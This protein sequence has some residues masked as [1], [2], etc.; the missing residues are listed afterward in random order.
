MFWDQNTMMPPGGAEARA[1]MADTLERTIHAR[2]TDPALGRLL[3][4]LEPWAAGQD[5]ESDDA[6]LDPLGAARLREGGP[7]ARRPRRRDH[8]A[9]ARRAAGL[10][11]GAGRERLLPLPRRARSATSSCATRYVAL[12]RGLRAPL[13]RA[14]RRLRARA[15]HRRA[16]ARC[17]RSCATGSSRSWPPPATPSSRA[18]TGVFN[19]TYP[20]A[21]QRAAVLGSST[22]SARTPTTGGWT[23]RSTRSP[24]AWRRP[25]SG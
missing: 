13:R 14:A 19:G 18:T 22:R 24:R 20:V 8:R 2:A 11:G 12:L 25:T 3:D 23:R 6:R 9:R 15:D 7:R 17:S 1:D 10:A 16:A 21:E 5:P 4:T